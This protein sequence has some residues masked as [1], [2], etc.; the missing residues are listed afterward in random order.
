LHLLLGPATPSWSDP[1]PMTASRTTCALSLV[2][3]RSGLFLSERYD[4][5]GL[6]SDRQGFAVFSPALP[7]VFPSSGQTPPLV[8]DEACEIVGE[9][10]HADLERRPGH[11]DGPD[12]HA[13]APFL[14]GEDMLDA[15]TDFGA[16]RVG[17]GVHLA[18]WLAGIAPV[19][20]L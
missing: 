1:S 4:V 12:E 7:S 14:M 16:R 19:M 2:N 10:G 20:D 13:H 17:L 11:A 9:I 3:E 18:Q 5:W 8:P 15:G 6:W